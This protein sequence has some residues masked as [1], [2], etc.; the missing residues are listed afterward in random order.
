MDV[1]RYFVDRKEEI[2]GIDVKDR[3]VKIDENVNFINS[4]V[5]PRRAGKSYFLYHFIKTHNLRDENY[6]FVNFAEIDVDPLEVPHLH[7]EIYGKFPRYLFF[8]EIQEVENWKKPIYALYEK[9]RYIM[10]ITGSNSR[11]LSREIAT[12]LRGRTKTTSIYPFSFAEI[13]KIENV[14]IDNIVSSY[15]ESKLKHIISERMKKGFFPDIVL[16]NIVPSAFF[17]EYIDLVIHKDIEERY[18][19]RNR[20]ALELFIRS[21][22]ASHT[23]QF[24]TNKV[25]NTLKSR[26]VKIGKDTLYNFQ[27]YLEDVFLCFFLRK[28]DFSYRKME[29]SVP[30]SF[31]VDNGLYTY[32]ERR[33]DAGK[34]MEGLVFSELVK[35]GYMPN[36]NLFYFN[37]RIG[38]VDFVLVN[39]TKVEECIQVTYASGKDEIDRREIRA[40]GKAV[41]ELGCKRKTVITWDYEG[42]GEIN[43][44]PLWKWLLGI[45]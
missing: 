7:N 30:K 18:G 40:L 36:R 35:R 14:K 15:T 43:Y 33:E 9:K 28:Y 19:V 38:E 13:L 37:D 22:I 2:R 45:E 26:G 17:A 3:L 12:E 31:L 25:Y 20:A 44:I 8:D 10:F 6:A 27:R 34:L 42:E 32:I 29:L 41:E 4:I 16:R 39:N 23:K 1:K 24:S 21:A 11:F 5:G